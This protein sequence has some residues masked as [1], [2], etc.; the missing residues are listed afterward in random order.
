MR[1]TLYNGLLLVLV[2]IFLSGILYGQDSH[3]FILGIKS[4]VNISQLN[5]NATFRLFSNGVPNSQYLNQKI[6]TN[7]NF[8]GTIEFGLTRKMSLVGELLLSLEG[9]QSESEKMYFS[10]TGGYENMTYSFQFTKLNFPLLWKYKFGRKLSM[11]IGPQLGVF[12]SAKGK[13][14]YFNSNLVNTTHY[15]FNMLEGGD[16]STVNR[17]KNKNGVDKIDASFLL[18]LTYD[19]HTNIYTQFRYSYGLSSIDM[20]LDF[21]QLYIISDFKLTI[22]QIAIGYRF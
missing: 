2:P 5:G 9:G 14:E 19:F 8:G 1:H 3:R 17:Y 18:A 15:S 6:T 16:I 21:D 20:N 12:L 4:G 13:F 11:E 22:F 10:L 7:I